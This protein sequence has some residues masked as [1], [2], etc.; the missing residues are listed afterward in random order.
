MRRYVY[1]VVFRIFLLVVMPLIF[2]HMLLLYSLDLVHLM[3]FIAASL[4]AI[5]V[6][7][8]AVIAWRF[9][10]F[11]DA[12]IQEDEAA[13]PLYRNKVRDIVVTA[14]HITDI[15]RDLGKKVSKISERQKLARSM[16]RDARADL[17]RAGEKLSI[18]EKN[19]AELLELSRGSHMI[20]D[21]AGRIYQLNKR[22]REYLGYDPVDMN[23]TDLIVRDEGYDERILE[24][25]TARDK[26]FSGIISHRRANG[27]S[28]ARVESSRL[29]G[30][31]Y[32]VTCS[33]VGDYIAEKS[34]SIL[35]NREI[36]Y[37]NRITQSLA[38]GE[39][40]SEMLTNLASTLVKLFDIRELVVLR[41]ADGIWNRGYT[42]GER[43]S[44]ALPIG[45]VREYIRR[46]GSAE[47]A[48]GGAGSSAISGGAGSVI[49]MCCDGGGREIVLCLY[50]GEQERIYMVFSAEDL[51]KDERDILEIF[52]AQVAVA[53][54]RSNDL[55]KLR[56]LFFRTVFAL[57]DVIEANDKYTEGHSYRVSHYAVQLG[58][59]L[60][61]SKDDLEKLETAGVLHDL[62]KV[63]VSR[64]VLQKTERLN[65][66]EQAEIRRHP[67][68]GYKII[69]NIDF[70]ERIKEAVAYH[71]VRYDLKG[72]P[73]DHGLSELPEFAA[74]IAV[75]DAFDAMTTKRAYN[76]ELTVAEALSEL[77]RCSGTQFAP[78][79]VD[80]MVELCGKKDLI[81]E[82]YERRRIDD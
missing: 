19:I 36:E 29:G 45:A 23:I 71:H 10:S 50:S 20:I 69:E 64:R 48:S 41:E 38:I 40:T 24:R 1:F 25:L 59:Q 17:K 53:I 30:G 27:A 42:L 76:N 49:G 31:M 15:N 5:G 80:A 44:E 22:Y 21:Y 39:G 11:F 68:D 77:Q 81:Q 12:E 55:E 35:Q 58:K 26:G 79:I 13:H 74:I 75:V 52:K 67:T 47:A 7:L 82:I 14:A 8:G 51:D 57:V 16:N 34:A 6:L 62:G 37:I 43:Y 28:L 46:G 3:P 54:Q 2:I 63:S 70:D 66:E 56:M 72:Y 60:G 18:A 65:D 61:Y 73:T 4:L 32:L 9:R 33:S 78:R